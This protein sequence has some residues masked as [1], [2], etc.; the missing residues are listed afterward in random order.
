MD[1]SRWRFESVGKP[2]TCRT[3]GVKR[4]SYPRF[5]GYAFAWQGRFITSIVSYDRKSCEAEVVELRGM[6][7]RKIYRQGGRII[8]VV[9][10]EQSK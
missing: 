9:M 6:P 8:R 1:L 7:W 10:T 4:M 3:A 2:K 5:H